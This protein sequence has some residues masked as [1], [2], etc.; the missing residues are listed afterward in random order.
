M[1]KFKENGLNAAEAFGWQ[2]YNLFMI[3]SVNTRT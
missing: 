1:E 3:K 2:K